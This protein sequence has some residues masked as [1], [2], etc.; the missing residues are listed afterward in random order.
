MEERGESSK[1]QKL[2]NGFLLFKH[3]FFFAAAA[4]TCRPFSGFKISQIF[5]IFLLVDFACVAEQLGKSQP[6]AGSEAEV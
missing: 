5:M 3:P 4:A 2:L 1:L 6:I